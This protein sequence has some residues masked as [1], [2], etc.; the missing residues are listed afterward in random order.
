MLGLTFLAQLQLCQESLA[1]IGD[2]RILVGW[3]GVG[4]FF[5]VVV[6]KIKDLFE[7]IKSQPWL[8]WSTWA[9]WTILLNIVKYSLCSLSI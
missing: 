5:V 7:E 8:C 3:G 1:F 2:L 6:V 4:W 9:E